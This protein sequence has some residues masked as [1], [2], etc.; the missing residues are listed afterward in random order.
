VGA[1]DTHES[2][3]LVVL[4]LK[5]CYKGF[6]RSEQ[7]FQVIE[8]TCEGQ[9]TAHLESFEIEADAVAME[10]L[11]VEHQDDPIDFDVIRI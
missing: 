8:L 6:N 9:I 10:Q 11:L 5:V 7:M 3:Y 2:I 1:I 4:I